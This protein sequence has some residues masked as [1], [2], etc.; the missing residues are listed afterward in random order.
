MRISYKISI[1]FYALSRI[2]VQSEFFYP[3]VMMLFTIVI[4]TDVLAVNEKVRSE[5]GNGVPN[6]WVCGSY[7]IGIFPTLFVSINEFKITL[8]FP[9]E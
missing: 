3:Q 1:I 2:N 4:T 8:T 9:Y 7:F 6:L 5:K